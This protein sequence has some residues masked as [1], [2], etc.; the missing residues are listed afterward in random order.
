MEYEA[1]KEE[2]KKIYENRGKEAIF[3]SKVKW[4]EQGE[5]PTKYFFNLEKMN[6]EKKLIREV[7]LKDRETITDP[8]KIEKELEKVQKNILIACHKVKM[9]VLNLLLRVLKSLN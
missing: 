1:A 3:R 5:K 2:L 8:K 4:F 9:R 6:Y 7:K